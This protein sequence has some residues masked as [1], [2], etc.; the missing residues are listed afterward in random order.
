MFE[1]GLI[2][3]LVSTVV[4]AVGGVL[5]K[6]ADN[7]AKQEERKMDL[8]LARLAAK[9]AG[10]ARIHDRAVAKEANSHEWDMNNA[11]NAKDMFVA[12]QRSF[13]SAVKTLNTGS[14]SKYVR[15]GLV[16]WAVSFITYAVIVDP[17]YFKQGLNIAETMLYAVGGIYA[18]QRLTRG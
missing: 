5:N 6:R 15:P 2:T 16:L 9:E 3:P 13:N 18:G 8:E 11:T 10:L 1:L 12:E 7:K 4:G 17:S 14:I